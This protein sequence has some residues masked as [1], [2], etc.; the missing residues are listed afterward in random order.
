MTNSEAEFIQHVGFVKLSLRGEGVI[1]VKLGDY[2]T[3]GSA[4][5]QVVIEVPNGLYVHDCNIYIIFIF[6]YLVY[7][8]DY[9]A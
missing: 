5:N 8:Q 4:V 9:Q 1:Q 7:S 2:T 3:T 6:Q